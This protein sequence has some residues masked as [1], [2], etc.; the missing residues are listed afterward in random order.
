MRSGVASRRE[1]D[2]LIA[3]GAVLVDGRRPPPT[4]TLIDPESASV[5]VDGRAVRPLLGH[6]HL[7]L[8]KPVGVMVTESDPE[9]RPTVADLLRAH[10]EQRRLM[11]VGRLDYD[12]SGLLLLTDDGELAHRLTHPRYG[13]PKEYLAVVRGMPDERD[14][15]RLRDGVPLEDG[16]TAP[17]EAEVVDRAAGGAVVRLV[18]TEGR[19]REVRRMLEAVGHPARELARTSFGPIKLGRLRAG[20]LHRL[21]EPEVRALRQAVGL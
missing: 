8:H 11:A 14:L 5:T 20:D 19:N 15:R 2:R 13:V 6:R 4:G 10:G 16:V 3:A 17:A 9:G 18:L 12:S 1:A 21:R 7:A